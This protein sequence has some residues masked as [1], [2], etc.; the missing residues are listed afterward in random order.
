M[1]LLG[2][3]SGISAR[4]FD[5]NTQ[6]L[7]DLFS[8]L[9]IWVLICTV[10]VLFCENRKLACLDVFLYCLGMNI[11]YYIYMSTVDNMMFKQYIIFWILV[12][13]ISPVL[14]FIVWVAP[15]PGWRGL[16]VSGGIVLFVLVNPFVLFGG[17]EIYDL[18]IAA[19]LVFIL[20]K[21]RRRKRN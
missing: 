18:I 17:P 14:A 6:V 3:V 20:Y 10:I 5:G 11:G 2:V 13:G 4:Y 19:I 9:S 16:L 15:K 7:A 21:F 1:A 8:E 12:A